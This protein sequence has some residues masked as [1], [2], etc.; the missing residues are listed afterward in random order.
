[1]WA[2]GSNNGQGEQ[3]GGLH[4]LPNE[5]SS[6]SLLALVTEL[7]DFG[8][9][10]D[11]FEDIQA[12][13]DD[14]HGQHEDEDFLVIC[15]EKEREIRELQFKLE[16]RGETIRALESHLKALT[17]K[18]ETSERLHHKELDFK[19][20]LVQQKEDKLQDFQRVMAQNEST[21][22]TRAALLD[23][24]VREQAKVMQLHNK[25]LDAA[26][27]L[28]NK[29]QAQAEKAIQ[30]KRE[31]LQTLEHTKQTLQQQLKAKKDEVAQLWN[32]ISELKLKLQ[33]QTTEAQQ[34]TLLAQEHKQQLSATL[35]RQQ[36]QSA[37]LVAAQHQVA[38][39]KGEVSTLRSEI[40]TNRKS[41]LADVEDRDKQLQSLGMKLEKLEVS[42]RH[43]QGV[44]ETQ[45]HQIK[46]LQASKQSCE[47][48]LERANCEATELKSQVQDYEGH[49]Q[50]LH[51]MTNQVHWDK[52]RHKEEM[53]R[54]RDQCDTKCDE[55]EK[56]LG[57]DIASAQAKNTSLSNSLAESSKNVWALGS[58]VS[59]LEEENKS[60]RCELGTCKE[61]NAQLS[62]DL[63]KT[64]QQ[65]NKQM[66]LKTQ[67]CTQ[68]QQRVKD[69]EEMLRAEKRKTHEQTAKVT[70]LIAQQEQQM[71]DLGAQHRQSTLEMASAKAKVMDLT[72]ECSK[73]QDDL[74]QATRKHAEEV[75]KRDDQI[76][77]MTNVTQTLEGTVRRLMALNTEKQQELDRASVDNKQYQQQIPELIEEVERLKKQITKLEDQLDD[78][79]RTEALQKQWNDELAESRAQLELSRQEASA[80]TNQLSIQGVESAG[81]R[82][83]VSAQAQ[84]LADLMEVLENSKKQADDEL[85]K[86]AELM[87]EMSAL[88]LD[89]KKL[90]ELKQQFELAKEAK[91]AEQQRT[92]ALQKQW[93][94][95]LA[96]SRAQLELSRQEASALTNRLSEETSDANLKAALNEVANWK[97]KVSQLNQQLKNIN[98]AYSALEEEKKGVYTRLGKE[99]ENLQ[100]S[101]ERADARTKAAEKRLQD[102]EA[103][104]QA[105]VERVEKKLTT[106]DANLKASQHEVNKWKA[107]AQDL[108]RSA[109][110]FA[111]QTQYLSNSYAAL[112]EDLKECQKK[113]QDARKKEQDAR[114][115]EEDARKE[116]A[117]QRKRADGLKKLSAE[118]L[119]TAGKAE[120]AAH[121]WKATA[122]RYQAEVEGL[123]RKLQASHA[124]LP[125]A[126]T[127]QALTG[128]AVT[129]AG[130]KRARPGGPAVDASSSPD[131][132]DVD[133]PSP[134]RRPTPLQKPGP[135]IAG[136]GFSS[137]LDDA[138]QYS[139]NG[140]SRLRDM[141]L[142]LGGTVIHSGT[143]TALATTVTHVVANPD[144]I[145]RTVLAAALTG[146]WIVSA[147]WVQKSMQARCWV[148]ESGYGHRCEGT[149]LQGKK[150]HIT[151]GFERVFE[152]IKDHI[153]RIR[154][155]FV[156]YGS[157]QLVN[158]VDEADIILVSELL[159]ERDQYEG[160]N[161]EV[162]TLQDFVNTSIGD[163]T[164]NHLLQGL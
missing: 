33:E 32:T 54:L 41:L 107:K 57:Q 68:L 159:Q 50:L 101:N 46:T 140:W 132:A 122:E 66:H 11:D 131:R 51:Q 117:K 77:S 60:L 65:H 154:A 53:Q 78:T 29:Y 81:L 61:T 24:K 82:G 12:D 109:D 85:T 90:E 133:A 146:R 59:C 150:I 103:E 19:Q 84:R 120:A 31:I 164:A 157:A 39:L 112:M 13:D 111:A 144:K 92:E 145:T 67:E 162:K 151:P 27:T 4:H 91:V 2:W 124:E 47:E 20:R 118:R 80:L 149:S 36:Q 70:T 156:D 127:E 40:Q 43:L 115:K 79:K 116:E 148:E 49:K 102:Q 48:R 52:Q 99:M 56:K 138:H 58:R 62:S 158:S 114:K 100:K 64:A 126:S 7:S 128:P 16:N 152:H 163:V 23:S 134:K 121:E 8:D 34:Q 108:K 86:N 96:E 76:L 83:Q 137:K 73:L 45:Q 15:G 130:R 10:D 63:E 105:K 5:E 161:K 142:R 125:V 55:L 3:G 72:V 110:D 28:A 44:T 98:G 71:G 26:N 17:N 136:S 89:I 104:Q 129:P 75:K 97:E 147:D 74:S 14:T 93:N 30:E 88:Q 22:A 9:E 37:E 87:Q 1:M 35:T 135:V 123:K 155:V 113:E 25:E 153:A 38:S 6:E 21:A 18:L 160:S 141:I 139:R 106:S 95:E 42:Q 119:E 94:D 143:Q 69:M